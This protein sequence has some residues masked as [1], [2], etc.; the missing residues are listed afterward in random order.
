MTG[1]GSRR[2]ASCAAN[3]CAG[4][5]CVVRWIRC[6]AR[7]AHHDPARRCAPGRSAKSSPAKK[8]P[9]TNATIRST[10]GLSC[11]DRTLA[12]SIRN[13]RSWAYS[14]NAAL[15]RGS[16]GCARSTIA[17][18]LSGMMILKMPPKNAHAASHPAITA[19]RSWRKLRCT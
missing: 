7:P 10:R 12:G 8:L 5:H 1:A 13:P 15:I 9:R 4:R 19:G 3:S 11:G 16:V 18:M 2:G 6:P 17:D 14:A